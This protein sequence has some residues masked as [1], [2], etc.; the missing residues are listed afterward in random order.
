MSNVNNVGDLC[1]IGNENVVMSIIVIE[2]VDVYVLGK[3]K[4]LVSWLIFVVDKE[5]IVNISN[6]L[7]YGNFVGILIE[8]DLV[9]IYKQEI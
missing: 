4:K 3:V 9:C 7:D 5:K 1:I 8:Q 2:V 6:L